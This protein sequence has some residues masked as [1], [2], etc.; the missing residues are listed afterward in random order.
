MADKT[1]LLVYAKDAVT[2]NVQQKTLTNVNPEASNAALKT[3]GQK[4]I[5]LTRDRYV[6]SQRVDLTELDHEE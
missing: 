4:M 2:D 5:G 1:S 3:L 6:K